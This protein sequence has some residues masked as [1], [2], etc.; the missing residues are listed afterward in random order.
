[1]Q[2]VT[3]QAI[4][5]RGAVLRRPGAGRGAVPGTPGA[6]QHLPAAWQADPAAVLAAP[7]YAGAAVLI[8]TADFTAG[9]TASA[10]AAVAGCGLAAVIAPEYSPGFCRALTKGDVFPLCLP[11]GKVTELQDIVE[12]DPWLMLTLHIGN[13]RVTAADYF[14]AEFEIAGPAAARPPGTA[15]QARRAEPGG[16]GDN[17]F[18]AAESA[19]LADRIRAAQ[20]HMSSLDMPA[21]VRISLQ[22]RLLAVCDSMKAAAADPARC[23]RRLASLTAEL[24]RIAAACEPGHFPYSN[25]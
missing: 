21:D 23:A 18:S 19:R 8:A 10:G 13:R 20:L 2:P 16:G 5:G 9:A 4:A 17:S 14:S 15:R 6:G 22:R 25:S 3:G 24:D 1:M 11:I 7:G 12:A